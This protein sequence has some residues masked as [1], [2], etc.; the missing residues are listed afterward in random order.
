MF[1]IFY[2]EIFGLIY[3]GLLKI[4]ILQ[5]KSTQSLGIS[6][7]LGSSWAQDLYRGS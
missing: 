6:V 2:I 3:V 1:A 7:S 4:H 5:L